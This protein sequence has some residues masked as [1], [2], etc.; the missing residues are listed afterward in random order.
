MKLPEKP[1][2]GIL[3]MKRFNGIEQ[4]QVKE[5]FWNLYND[6]GMITLCLSLSSDKAIEQEEDTASFFGLLSWELNLIDEK[7]AD[8]KLQAG[9]SAVIPEA[10]DE[11]K[12]GW[13][14]NFYYSS[15]EGSDNN[16]IEI[17]D[18]KDD[19]LL[20]KLTG[21]IMDVNY[22]DNSKPKSQLLLEAWFE[23]D[24]KTMRSMS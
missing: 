15:H 21:E 17:L 20:L 16:K 2:L 9:F 1:T 5:T 8:N 10:Y 22:Y 12:E 3:F 24:E 14:T 23:H 13:I 18:R 4:Y 7:L 19:Q 6:A 11:S